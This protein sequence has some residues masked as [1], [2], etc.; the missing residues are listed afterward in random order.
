MVA[1]SVGSGLQVRSLFRDY[2]VEF[3]DDATTALSSRLDPGKTFVVCDEKVFGLWREF[4]NP[5]FVPGRYKVIAPSEESKTMEKAQEL[6]EAMIAAG[7]RRDHTV[8]AIGGGVTQDVSAFAAS[9]LYRGIEWTFIPTT[10]LA[11]ADSCVGSKTSINV[12]DK[13]N[14]AGNF[15]PPSI[16]V[17]D[18]R[19]L[20]TLPVDDVRSGIGEM[21]HFYLYA[22]SPMTRPLLAGYRELLENRAALRP[23][24]EES[25][26]IKRRVAELDEFDRHERH[27]FNYGHTFGHALES[28]TDYV[29]PHGLAITVGMDIANFVSMRLGLMPRA[30]FEELH[31][32]LIL[33]FPT[34][35]FEP[36]QLDRYFEYLTK[37]KKNL[38]NDLGCILAERPGALVP[39]QI[40]F[41][42]ALRAMLRE[43]FAGQWWQ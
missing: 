17:I 28:V 41:D 3:S 36:S 23:F 14:L 5:L 1:S 26:Q 16:A 13:K 2:R 11:Q 39:R 32:L 19:F 34:R 30:V 9:I 35:Q 29:I 43:Y 12:R 24:I 21:L 10:L 37:D 18:T 40:P 42:D 20:D 22:D 4:L 15:W 38:G 25:L 33:N 7:T 27:K 8:L 6:I 31:A